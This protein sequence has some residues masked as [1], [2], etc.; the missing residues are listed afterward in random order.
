V[1]ALLSTAWLAGVAEVIPVRDEASVSLVREAVRRHAA[2]QA[3]TT[4][5][6]ESLAAA[7]SE[8]AHNQRKHARLGAVGVRAISRTGVAG[9]EVIAADDGPGIADPAAAFRDLPREGGPGLGI[10]LAAAYRLA[11]ELDVDVRRGEGT[12]LWARKF[13]A[14]LPRQEVAVLGRPCAGEARSGD[15]AAFVRDDHTLLLAVVDGL[16]HGAPARVAADQAIATLRAHAAD[17]PLEILTACDRELETTRGAVM[18]VGRFDVRTR[19]LE[20]A[21]AGNIATRVHRGGASTGFL[22]TARVLGA[23]HRSVRIPVEQVTLGGES[24]VLMFTDGLTTRTDLTGQLEL[25]RQ[26]P[27]AIAQG[28][29]D[30]FGRT[31][32]DALVMVARLR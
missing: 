18:S 13:A 8:L 24:I 17:S 15:H 2:A 5:A 20:H 30:R 22:S 25:L 11:D 9:V 29:L 28:L 3:L 14:A 12:C 27:L 21:G 16:G 6:S 4:E 32:D 31:N 10:G 23:R 26:P 19:E 7:A 1:G